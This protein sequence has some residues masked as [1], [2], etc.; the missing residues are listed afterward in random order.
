MA[1]LT[2][3]LNIQKQINSLLQRRSELLEKSNKVLSKQALLAKEVHEAMAGKNLEGLEARLR[4]INQGFQ[5]AG[6]K[7]RKAAQGIDEM[8][9]SIQEADNDMKK[10]NKNTAKLA[11]AVGFLKG[12]KSGFKLV[13]SVVR[14]A[15]RV[16]GSFVKS[17]FNI[18]KAILARP[19]KIFQGLVDMSQQ[20]GSP[21]FRQA[22]EE[23][24]KTFGDIASGSGLALRKSVSEMRKEFNGLTGGSRMMGASFG[25]VFGYGREGM[26]AALKENAE[27]ATHLGGSFAQLREELKGNYAELAIY[28]KGLGF[29]TEQQALL[30]KLTAKS[31]GDIMQRQKELSQLASGVGKAFGY[32]AKEVGSGLGE[33]FQDVKTFGGFTDKQLVQIRVQAMRLGASMQALTGVAQG[34]DD[35][36]KAQ[37]N[38]AFLNRAFG[39]TVDTMKIFREQ[40]PVKRIQMLQQS[41]AATGRDIGLMS[42]QELQYFSQAVGVSEQDAKILFAKKNLQMDYNAVKKVTNAEARK[43][44]ST[45]KV[46]RD[47]SKQIERVFGSGGEKYQGFFDALGKGFTKGVRR[48]REMR[49]VMRNLNRSLRHTDFAGQ[50]LGRNFVKYFPG[51]KQLLGAL[52][53]FFDPVKLIPT[54]NESNKHLKLFFQQLSGGKAP[55]AAF[56]ILAQNMMGT[57]RTYFG[58]KGQALD[59]IKTSIDTILT[60]FVNIKL[61]MYRRAASSAAEGLRGM[62]EVLKAYN[63]DPDGTMSEMGKKGGELFGSRFGDSANRL[64]KTIQFDLFP[65]I[66]AAAPHLFEAAKNL[67]STFRNFLYEN[68][69]AIAEALKDALLFVMKMK[70][71]IFKAIAGQA[72]T[73]PA[74]AGLLATMVLGPA[75]ASGFTHYVGAKLAASMAGGT[76]RNLLTS[77]AARTAAANSFMAWA[78]AGQDA[79]PVSALGRRMAAAR[80]IG[81]KL[82]NV[83]RGFLSKAWPV[84]LAAGIGTGL[85]KGIKKGIET[86]DAK[87]ALRSFG[88]GLISGLT[89]GMLDGDAL[90]N[91]VFGEYIA[92]PIERE[93][94]RIER[95]GTLAEQ[96]LVASGRKISKAAGSY[97]EYANAVN[98]ATG[99]AKDLGRYFEDSDVSNFVDF[100]VMSDNFDEVLQKTESAFGE[101]AIARRNAHMQK[102]R[103]VFKQKVVHTSRHTRRRVSNTGR[104][105][106]GGDLNALFD[107]EFQTR[108]RQKAAGGDEA[109]KY[110]L[111]SMFSGIIEQVGADGENL[112]TPDMERQINSLITTTTEELNVAA[113]NAAQEAAKIDSGL[114]GFKQAYGTG[115][116]AGEKRVRSYQRYLQMQYDRLVESGADDETVLAPL[117]RKMRV[118]NENLDRKLTAEAEKTFTDGMVEQELAA[119]SDKY[120]KDKGLAAGSPIPE[121]VTAKLRAQAE[122]R[123]IAAVRNGDLTALS[124]EAVQKALA[125]GMEEQGL[126][127]RLVA[128]EETRLTELEAVAETVNRISA[129]E[130]LPE[131]LKTLRE[132]IALVSPEELKSDAK[133]LVEAAV[134]ITSAVQ[135]EMEGKLDKPAAVRMHESF[136]S[137]LQ[138]VGGM[139]QSIDLI[140]NKEA[141]DITT[142]KSR[143]TDFKDALLSMHTAMQEIGGQTLTTSE[144]SNISMLSNYMP[145]IST[146][147]LDSLPEGIKGKLANA[148]AAIDTA[149]E[150]ARSIKQIGGNVEGTAKLVDAINA[151]GE[152][153]VS[154]A[155]VPNLNAHFTIEIDT[156]TL[157]EKI[158]NAKF[159][160]SG[161]HG[162]QIRTF[163]MPNGRSYYQY[164]GGP[165][166]AVILP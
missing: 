6:E 128:A 73:D 112:L 120:L 158:V 151:G 144:K 157:T 16:V 48:T 109:A 165:P 43:E 40:D 26:A 33:M 29:T 119:L 72:V 94:A 156:D 83:T 3:Q 154:M 27:L 49:K 4:Q 99:A 145:M 150:M 98:Q 124:S 56:N 7:A 14:G 122:A 118:V 38:V 19:F 137:Q 160:S 12:L 88:G 101:R 117:R 114:A 52:A 93:L 17:L 155:G 90:I 166:S 44:V 37:Q 18:G 89:L 132:K 30:I 31:G 65:A 91:K 50:Q 162:D 8:K 2:G 138:T 20:M 87:Q 92:D 96:S 79:V 61:E 32:S 146:G 57:L 97:R 141:P 149:I 66:E 5:E 71:E 82:V 15:V 28:R 47:L 1:D 116:I 159:T 108:I 21:V 113:A 139:A 102:L 152:L 147:V 24:R 77:G 42:R 63:T 22:L 153:T 53:D 142:M 75:F 100:E 36:E 11:G 121:S 111:E 70:F 68:R 148:K 9:D 46:L 45:A 135:E 80:G 55:A 110:L 107:E 69:H 164:S 134:N 74:T 35:Y 130:A 76:I 133:K 84:A 59:L 34:F 140:V 51:V 129:L 86:G 25:R 105:A 81:G 104:R 95:S 78:T 143:I 106:Q 67:M 10:F 127:E 136:V 13:G 23:V 115:G 125:A 62:T 85:F 41:F 64:L 163:L 103:Q 60:L 39:M 126:G 54:L 131:K 123:L 161:G 58:E